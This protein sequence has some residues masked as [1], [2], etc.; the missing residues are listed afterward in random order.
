MLILR[1]LLLLFVVQ[2]NNSLELIV[3]LILGENELVDKPVFA[4]HDALLV[5]D[6]VELAIVLLKDIILVVLLIFIVFEV[7]VSSST[8]ITLHVVSVLTFSI[9][10][11]EHVRLSFAFL[12]SVLVVQLLQDV[13]DLA[14]KLVVDLVHQVLQHL[15]HAQLL[16]LLTELLASE[17]GVKGTVDIGSNLRVLMLYKL[18][19]NLE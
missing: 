16:G 18:V 19:E 3:T 6:V 4:D 14:L 11:L 10:S 2:V 13:L 9:L 5:D 1:L 15:W 7:V 17:D 8:I 12:L